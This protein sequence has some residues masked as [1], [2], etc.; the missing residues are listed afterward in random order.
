MKNLQQSLIVIYFKRKDGIP[1]TRDEQRIWRQYRQRQAMEE[2]LDEEALEQ[3]ARYQH[4][5]PSVEQF[6]ERY[7]I[8]LTIPFPNQQKQDTTGRVRSF[9]LRSLAVAAS[10]I[11]ALSLAWWNYA[12]NKSQES[13]GVTDTNTISPGYA[14]ATLQLANGQ[15]IT[16]DTTVQNTLPSQGNAYLSVEQPGILQYRHKAGSEEQQAGTN[17]LHTPKGGEYQLILSDGTKVWLNAATELRYPPVFGSGAREVILE[18]GEAYFEV[19][20]GAPQQPFIVRAKDQQIQ[21]LGTQFNVKAYKEEATII[22]T[23]VEGAVRVDQGQQTR[24]LT[25]GQQAVTDKQGKL[26]VAAVDLKEVTAWKY[27]YFIFHDKRLSEIMAEVQRWYNVELI[28]VDPLN[29]ERFIVD[30][31]PRSQPVKGLLDNLEASRLVRFEIKGRKI[32]IRK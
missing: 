19:A 1:L 20:A 12:R 28:Y 29:D 24:M 27:K 14:R 6:F 31:F 25:P 22:T 21:A 26:S 4:Q 8:P 2:A 30:E 9:P 32:Y 15:N 18:E 7:E 3:L 13:V 16:V 10:L 23:L 5:M 11:I 17:T